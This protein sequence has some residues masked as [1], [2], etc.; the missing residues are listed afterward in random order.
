MEVVYVRYFTP[1]FHSIVAPLTVARQASLHLEFSRQVWV[2]I[3]LPR[4][5]SRLRDRT[6]ISRASCTGRRILDD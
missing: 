1:K 5:S 2:A 4:G 3:S 6:H